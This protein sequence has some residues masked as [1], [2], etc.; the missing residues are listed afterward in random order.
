MSN[1]I[2]HNTQKDAWPRPGVLLRGLHIHTLLLSRY[3]LNLRLSQALSS[4][5]AYAGER[6]ELR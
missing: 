5:T 2:S 6:G 3:K 4:E 1:N